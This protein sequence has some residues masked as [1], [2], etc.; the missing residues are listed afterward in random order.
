[1]SKALLVVAIGLVALFALGSTA[2]GTDEAAIKAEAKAEALAEAK[3]EAKA[4]A[5]AK[6]KAAAKAKARRQAIAR[7]QAERRA[8][9]ARAR[10]QAIAA[11]AKERM[12]VK[13]DRGLELTGEG[14]RVIEEMQAL[15]Q[16]AMDYVDAGDAAGACAVAAEIVPKLDELDGIVSD[17]EALNVPGV[18]DEVA[19]LTQGQRTLH[20]AIG[21]VEGI[22]S[23]LG[24]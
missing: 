18:D 9:A 16:E 13:A 24:Y 7:A 22:C 20:S 12:A 4:E 19:G 1:M 10:R 15:Q 5:L 8:A 6:A 3:A 17:I 2:C 21:K 23:T 14:T 11:A